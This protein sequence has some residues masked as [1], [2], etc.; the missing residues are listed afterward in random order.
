MSVL[1]PKVDT[2]FGLSLLACGPK[3]KRLAK[4]FTWLTLEGEQQFKF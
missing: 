3:G 4:A 2:E 1:V